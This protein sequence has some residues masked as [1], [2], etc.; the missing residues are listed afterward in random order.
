MPFE[1]LE[2]EAIADIAFQASNET[3]EDLFKDAAIAIFSLQ[4]DIQKLDSN[5]TYQIIIEEKSLERLFY[6]FLDEIVYLKDADLFFPKIVEVDSVL[7]HNTWKLIGRF[8][9]SKFDENI[10][11][12]GNDVKA[13]TLHEFYIKK[14]QNGWECHVI[15]DI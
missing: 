6:K 9:G 15:I 14:T 7:K 5:L 4:T 10:H 2:D 3:L 11:T 1:Y 8:I 12:I 13:I